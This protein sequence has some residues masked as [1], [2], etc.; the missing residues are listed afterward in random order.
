MIVDTSHPQ[1]VAALADLQDIYAQFKTRYKPVMDRMTKAELVWLYQR[2]PLLQE[3]IK[4]S[5]Q[6]H[7]YVERAGFDV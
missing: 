3:F 5:S 4:I 2:D 1:Y 7:G 6:V